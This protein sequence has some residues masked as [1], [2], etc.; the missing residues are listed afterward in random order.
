MHKHLFD[1]CVVAKWLLGVG[2]NLGE[3]EMLG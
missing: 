1:I 2:V 3:R